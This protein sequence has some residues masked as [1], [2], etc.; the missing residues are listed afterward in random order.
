MHV[1]GAAMTIFHVIKYQPHCPVTRKDLSL[2]PRDL[3]PKWDVLSKKA[4]NELKRASQNIE[5][6]EETANLANQTYYNIVIKLLLEY[7]GP[8]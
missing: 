8:I 5:T 7:Q 6:I 2:L 3:L 4:H 1:H